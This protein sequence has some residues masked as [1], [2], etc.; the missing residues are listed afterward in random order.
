MHRAPANAAASAALPPRPAPPRPALA[1]VGI[2]VVALELNRKAKEDAVKRAKDEERRA[3]MRALHQQHLK[4]ETVGAGWGEGC[5]LVGG[6][7]RARLVEAVC[8]PRLTMQCVQGAGARCSV[9]SVPQRGEGRV[10]VRSS[11]EVWACATLLAP[12]QAR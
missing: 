2:G 6:R 11:W 1:Q 7:G 4:A 10:L 12:G 9:L 5:S 8:L 3:E